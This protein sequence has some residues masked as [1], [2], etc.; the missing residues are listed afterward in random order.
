MGLAAQLN[1]IEKG[2]EI[3][4]SAPE[5]M[6][7]PVILGEWDPEH[8][9]QNS[10]RNGALYACYTAEALSRTLSLAERE[11]LNLEGL[12][13]WAFE[14]EDQPFFAGFRELATNGIDKPVL[15]GFRMFGLMGEERADARSSGAR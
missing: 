3:I 12:V 4:S 5:W 15:N 14:F 13:T 2:F 7:I 1:S 9:P 8:A 11:H 6:S 10:Y